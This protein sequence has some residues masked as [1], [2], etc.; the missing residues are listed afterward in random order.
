MQHDTSKDQDPLDDNLEFD[1]FEDDIEIDGLDDDADWDDEAIDGA[2]DDDFNDV[3]AVVADSGDNVVTDSP[4][5]DSNQPAQAKT[6]LQKYF[7]AL[8]GGVVVIFVG[9]WLLAQGGGTD[10]AT[11]PAPS[12][13]AAF[14][15]ATPTEEDPAEMDNA[16]DTFEADLGLPPMPTPMQQDEQEEIVETPAQDTQESNTAALTPLPIFGDNADIRKVAKVTEV[17][18]TPIEAPKKEAAALFDA[19][20]D[21]LTPLPQ[22]DF[23]FETPFEVPV[24]SPSADIAPLNDIEFA[25]VEMPSPVPSKDVSAELDTS[26]LAL[27]KA[28]ADYEA[29]LS[30]VERLKVEKDALLQENKSLETAV[31][32][33]NAELSS[34]RNDLK[35]MQK[36]ASQAPKVVQKPAPAVTKATTPTPMPKVQAKSAAPRVVKTESQKTWVLRSAQPGKATLAEKDSSDLRSVEIGSSVSGLGKIT[37]IGVEGGK[38]I[39]RGTQGVVS[40]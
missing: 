19:P 38:W 25:D 4:A 36:K 1:D 10:S 21:A 23:D 31:D 29:L 9:L 27:E 6:F 2:L 8:V 11:I 35:V 12:E 16:S 13:I 15:S 24:L 17:V 28:Q 40:Q 37:F 22:D 7:Y 14:D 5:P 18:E 26:A 30:E 32:K 34:L 20:L 3:D 39:V 33:N